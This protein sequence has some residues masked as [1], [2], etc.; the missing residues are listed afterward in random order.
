MPPHP[1]FYA[2]RHVLEQV[3]RFDPA[4]STSADYDFILRALAPEQFSLH[5]IPHVLVDY[6]LGGLSS[7]NLR[8]TVNGNLK[9]LRA[10]RAHLG[11]GLVDL[12]L[13][14]RPLG[15]LAQLRRVRGYYKS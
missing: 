5:Y 1:T 8:A 7:K 11:A 12:G 2:R 3:G 4:Y 15:K 14:A 6:Q 9:C 10:R 13:I